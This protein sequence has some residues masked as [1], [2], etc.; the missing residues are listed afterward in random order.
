[1]NVPH[2]AVDVTEI[3]SL[4]ICPVPRCGWRTIQLSE[5]LARLRYAEHYEARH[6]VSTPV[7]RTCQWCG[8]KRDV[9][10]RK[11]ICADCHRAERAAKA[12]AAYKA[13]GRPGRRAS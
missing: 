3:T 6:R 1:M 13:K 12:R 10:V 8:S 2:P 5:D 9:L 11:A 7:G 4:A